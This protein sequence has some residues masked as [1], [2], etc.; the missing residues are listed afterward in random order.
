MSY[1]FTNGDGTK[2]LEVKKKENWIGQDAERHR[3]KVQ[4][5]H[6]QETVIAWC[7]MGGDNPE[8]E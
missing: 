3:R 7:M 5:E 4:R 8:L 1:L 6:P 2:V